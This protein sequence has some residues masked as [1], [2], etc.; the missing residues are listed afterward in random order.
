MPVMW[1]CSEIASKRFIATTSATALRGNTAIRGFSLQI[2]GTLL[3]AFVILLAQC[4]EERYS[5]QYFTI[6]NIISL[7]AHIQKGECPIAHKD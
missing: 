5:W 3:I 4:Q 7:A 2:R 1:C 6:L